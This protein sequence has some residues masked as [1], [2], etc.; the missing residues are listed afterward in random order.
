MSMYIYLYNIVHINMI[1][2]VRAENWALV[3]ACLLR[4]SVYQLDVYIYRERERDRD[5]KVKQD[6]HPKGRN[7]R[8]T[9]STLITTID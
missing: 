3:F 4:N 1:N 8:N 5:V 9:M 7:K 2:M 6:H